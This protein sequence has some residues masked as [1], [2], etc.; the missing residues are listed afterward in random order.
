MPLYPCPAC[1]REV[2]QSA[3]TCPNCGHPL[4]PQAVAPEAPKKPEPK[5]VDPKTAFGC[6]T[7][8]LIILLIAMLPKC[9]KDEDKG[10]KPAAQ[11]TREIVYNSPW[12]GSVRQVERWLKNNL[13]DPDSFQAIEWS[14]VT[15]TSNGFMVRCKYRAKNSFGGY[16]VEERVFSLDG[17]GEVSKVIDL[18]AK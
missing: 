8:I 6:G 2:S 18:H 17:T 5:P 12:D 16:V 4:L 15:K 13:K 7:V 11:E 3:T 14:P 1:G 10:A 9:G